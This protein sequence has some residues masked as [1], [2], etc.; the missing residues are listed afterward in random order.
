MLPSLL[1]QISNTKTKHISPT[2]HTVML[3]PIFIYLSIYRL[4]N[5]VVNNA[6]CMKPDQK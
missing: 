5:N 1:T 2:I 6:D 3:I 4:L